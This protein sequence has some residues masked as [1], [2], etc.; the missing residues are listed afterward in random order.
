LAR[1]SSAGFI[2]GF[3]YVPRIDKALLA[4][5]SEGVVA[6]TGGLS[7]EIPHLIL[8]VGLKQAEEAFLWYKEVFGDR[9]YAELNRHGLPE[10][11]VV[12][13][14][15]LGFCKTHG[16]PFVPANNAFYLDRS[17][18]EAH[19]ILLCVKDS[20]KKSTP[21]GRGRGFR[22]G[23]PNDRFH[24]ASQAEMRRSFADLPE[25]FTHLERLLGRVEPFA[26]SRE[27]LLPKF[28]I[29]AEFVHPEDE[30]DGG[31]RGENAYLR[32]LTLEGAKRRYGSPW[33]EEIQE[34]LD[35]ELATIEKTG[36]PGYFLIVQD[37]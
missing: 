31:K 2:E 25:G 29:P 36:Y 11:D 6:L 32:H 34:R 22:Y 10:E 7:G 8:N 3:Y 21:V 4:E 13:D 26:L 33:S 28:E 1:L 19:D 35:F 9:F 12:N 5:Y 14:T 30:Q 17:E 16:V 23:M 18:A 27:V 37:F 24:M 20:E 15:L